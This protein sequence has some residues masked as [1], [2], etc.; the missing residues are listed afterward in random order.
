MSSFHRYAA[1]ASHFRTPT[2]VRRENRLTAKILKIWRNRFNQ[3]F[4][5]GTEKLTLK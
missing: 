3:C 4:L 2:G 5:I 1:S